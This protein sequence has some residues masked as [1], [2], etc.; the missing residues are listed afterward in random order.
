MKMERYLKVISEMA[1]KMEEGNS[2]FQM[3]INISEN[4][5]TTYIMVKEF[6]H[7]NLENCMKVISYMDY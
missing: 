7:G 6:I 5:K 4:L 2:L 1:K 3:E